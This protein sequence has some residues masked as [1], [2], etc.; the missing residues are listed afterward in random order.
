L[1]SSA[2]FQLGAPSAAAREPVHFGAKTKCLLRGESVFRPTRPC[3]DDG[4]LQCT[5]IGKRELPGHVGKLHVH[6]IQVGCRFLR[7]LSAGQE[8]DAR[9][10]S[11]NGS[12]ETP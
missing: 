5:T 8:I 2:F 9:D 4:I 6:R 10:S 3:L 12:L 11:W 1:A 7:T